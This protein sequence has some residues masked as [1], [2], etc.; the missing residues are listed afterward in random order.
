[1]NESDRLWVAGMMSVL[2]GIRYYKKNVRLIWQIT[3]CQLELLKGIQSKTGMG[4]LFGPYNNGRRNPYYRFYIQGPNLEALFDELEPHLVEHVADEGRRAITE[5]RNRPI[6]K[7][8]TK[9]I[10]S[11]AD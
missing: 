11:R 2:G 8:R 3:S 7:P 5:W 10:A 9:K 1:M 6:K 4:A